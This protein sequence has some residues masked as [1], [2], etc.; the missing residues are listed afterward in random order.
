M[1]LGFAVTGILCFLAKSVSMKSLELPESIRAWVLTDWL[2]NLSVTG[3]MKVSKIGLML[4][5]LR[6]WLVSL[7]RMGSLIDPGPWSLKEISWGMT[8]LGVQSFHSRGRGQ[9]SFFSP[10]P[11]WA[12]GQEWGRQHPVALV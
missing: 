3:I 11:P 7:S 8:W 1:G 9:G 10:F 4:A 6:V 5:S 12:V 2:L